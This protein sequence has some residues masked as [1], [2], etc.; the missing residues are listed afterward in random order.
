MGTQLRWMH[1]ETVMYMS[2]VPYVMYGLVFVVNFAVALLSL[3]TLRLRWTVAIKFAMAVFLMCIVN[4]A[5]ALF[6]TCK[7]KTKVRFCYQICDGCPS[8]V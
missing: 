7:T 4:F 6:L 3:V 8:H 5:V 1:F 2:C